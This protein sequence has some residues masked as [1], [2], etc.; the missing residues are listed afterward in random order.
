MSCLLPLVVKLPDKQLRRVVG[1]GKGAACVVF[2]NLEVVFC[3][4]IKTDPIFGVS[5]FAS[6]SN[7]LI[8]LS[9]RE[10]PLPSDRRSH[11]ALAC[12]HVPPHGVAR[13]R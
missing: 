10:K 3:E 1:D 9:L 7:I 12:G 2:A 6:T 5:F 4:G 13:C 8:H 11:G